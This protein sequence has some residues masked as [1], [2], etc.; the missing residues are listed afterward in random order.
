MRLKLIG[1]IKKVS[2]R[3]RAK[4]ITRLFKLLQLVE[5]S[6]ADL[7]QRYIADELN[8]SIGTTN[9]LLQ[10]AEKKGYI[11]IEP[12]GVGFDPENY[13]YLITPRG[14]DKKRSLTKSV[15]RMKIDEFK[16]LKEE[17]NKIKPKD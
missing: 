15:Y 11:K 13:N 5:N 17:I 9:S 10:D 12:K 2:P 6:D 1:K 7:S 16:D 8:L 3:K 14:E 4:H